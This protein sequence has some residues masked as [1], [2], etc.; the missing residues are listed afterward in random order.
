M[1]V[2]WLIIE[3]ALFVILLYTLFR[4]STGKVTTIAKLIMTACS[5]GILAIADR[6]KLFIWIAIV[7]LIWILKYRK[8][9][10]KKQNG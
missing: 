9:F 1:E 2:T 8:M 4:V 10:K 3:I 5:I 7:G 6:V